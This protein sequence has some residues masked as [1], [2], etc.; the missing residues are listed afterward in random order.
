MRQG[1]PLSHF[2]CVSI[3]D[4][5]FDTFLCIGDGDFDTF[6]CIGDKG[7]RDSTRIIDSLCLSHI[8][9]NR[10]QVDKG[11]LLYTNLIKPGHRTAPVALSVFPAQLVV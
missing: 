5:G 9:E 11:T 4:G 6:L 10:G 7:I 2:L 3:G 1:N 8:F